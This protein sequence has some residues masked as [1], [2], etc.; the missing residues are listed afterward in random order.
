ML[1]GYKDKLKPQFI[2]RNKINA[3]KRTILKLFI[4]KNHSGYKLFSS[5]DASGKIKLCATS[6]EAVDVHSNIAQKSSISAIHNLFH[7]GN[8][9]INEL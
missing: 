9:N 5:S 1:S 4:A 7:P 3:D 8:V 2:S 6:L